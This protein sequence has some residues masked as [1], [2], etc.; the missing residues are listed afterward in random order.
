[1][2][3]EHIPLSGEHSIYDMNVSLGQFGALIADVINSTFVLAKEIS[4][5]QGNITLVSTNSTHARSESET[6]QS[7]SI[8]EGRLSFSPTAPGS[9]RASL[10]G[11][12][13]ARRHRSSW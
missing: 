3:Y 1:M 11:S 2:R 7:A 12:R 5:H 6:H 9:W 13:P 10:V 8:S 4:S